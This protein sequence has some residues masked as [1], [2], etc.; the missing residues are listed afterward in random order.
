MPLLLKL[1]I[2]ESDEVRD[3][4]VLKVTSPFVVRLPVLEMLPS[5]DIL[6]TNVVVLDALFTRICHPYAYEV[7]AIC[8]AWP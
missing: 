5:T 2:A 7:P 3:V 8:A 6:E 4:E 1:V